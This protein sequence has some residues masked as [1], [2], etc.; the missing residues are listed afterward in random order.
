M[1][2]VDTEHI[3]LV[4]PFTTG[5]LRDPSSLLGVVF[6]A[7]QH[8]TKTVTVAFVTPGEE[9]LYP[10]LLAAPKAHW[11]KLQHFLGKVYSAL[12]AG[13]WAADR[14]L[15]DVEVRFQGEGEWSDR[16]LARPDRLVVLDCE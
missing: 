11:D 13:H 5:L 12:A 4:L 7:A 2:L 6:T 1:T 9:Q 16:V 3:L 15:V 8:A 14:I 10:S